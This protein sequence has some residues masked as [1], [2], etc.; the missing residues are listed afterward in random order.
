[1]TPAFSLSCSRHGEGL[2]L[3]KGGCLTVFTHSPN[4]LTCLASFLWYM[5]WFR[6]RQLGSL[7]APAA[8]VPFT[9]PAN[10]AAA[11]TSTW[12]LL[13]SDTSSNLITHL[14]MIVS[15][16]FPLMVLLPSTQLL[17][18][19]LIPPFSPDFLLNSPKNS[20]KSF[21]QRQ[22]WWLLRFSR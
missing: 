19:D 15:S 5:P 4:Q 22:T 2:L 6:D 12:S 9:L 20:S 7:L 8:M 13:Q 14:N 1:M 17:L 3:E 16:Q 10:P 11:D 18:L 21:Q